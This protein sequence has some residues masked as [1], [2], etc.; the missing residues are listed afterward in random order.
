MSSR[1][2]PSSAANFVDRHALWTDAQA[3]AAHAVERAIKR[4]KLEVVRFSFVDQH[5]VL[6]GKTLVASEASRAMRD[7]VTMTSTLFAKD[8]SHRNVFPVFESGGGMGVP[9]MEG[10]GNFVM[11]ADPA[12]F[13]VLPWAENT[14]WLLCDS[15]F[16]NGKPVPFATRQLYRDALSKLAKAGFD[17]LAGLEVEFHLLK[18][19]DLRLAPDTLTWPPEPPTVIHTTH[20]F[21][22]LTEGRFDQVGPIMDVLR[23][24]VVALGLPLRSLEVELGPSQFEFT[25]A[26]ELG[27]A[28]ADMMVLFRS[29]IKQ[30][31]RRHGYLVSFMCRPRLPNTL[32]SGWHLHQSLLHAKSKANAFVS[33]DKSEL[34]SPLGRNFLAG[35]LTHARAAAAFT[36]PTINGYKRYHG[37]N[38]MAP[39]QA[40]WARDNRGVMVRVMG[41]PGDPA[42]HL[43]NRVGEPLANPY[44]YMASQV[45]AG[46]DGMARRLN[47]GP[48]ADAPYEVSAE[49]LPKTLEEALKALRKDECFRAG[50]GEAFVNY[51]AHIKE[52]EIARFCKE[53]KNYQ[54]QTEVTAWEQREYF[55][56]F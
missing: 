20:G 8:T 6:R 14:G 48:S 52:A 15:Y 38:S 7:G 51:Y 53:T 39:I 56:L 18:I 22:Y 47:P 30:V 37:V 34:L 35:L 10:A 42:T 2:R 17:Y 36:T 3:K 50:F 19:E 41:D 44:L 45:H 33:R 26:P 28:S 5:G 54:D 46:L 4:H 55:D 12:T 24:N 9:E 25:F 49:P 43:E 16:T 40:I 13:R 23:K 1:Q 11:V 27:L 21:Q 32:A 29:A 31:A